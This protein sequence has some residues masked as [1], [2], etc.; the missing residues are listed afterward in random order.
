MNKKN[1]RYYEDKSHYKE[2]R[3]SDRR[4]QKSQRHH[5]KEWLNNI[6]TQNLDND[7]I[8]DKIDE[9]QDTQWSD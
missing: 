3:S 5:T 1:K 8:C 2:M 9:I 7:D 6:T 4:K